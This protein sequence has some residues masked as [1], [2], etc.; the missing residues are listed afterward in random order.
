MGSGTLLKRSIEKYGIDKFKK[1]ILY[2]FK[3]SEEM[4][5]M[6]KE[7]VNEAFVAREDTYN[8]SEGG[9]GSWK[10]LKGKN[11]VQDKNGNFCYVNICD[12]PKKLE[13]G[14]VLVKRVVVKDISGN[15]F[16]VDK[17]DPRYISGELVGHTKGRCPVKD[18]TGNSFMV[19]VNNPRYLSGELVG[20]HTGKVNVVDKEENMLQVSIYDSR[21]LS[22]EL[23]CAVIVKDNNGK[24]FRI[25]PNNIK[26]LSGELKG[27]WS[28]KKHK[29]ETKNKIKNTMLQHKHQQG[30]KNS[31][32]G[33]CWIHNI[34]LKK[35]IVIKKEE[36][37]KYL[38]QNWIKGRKLIF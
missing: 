4:F 33:K 14:F 6:E 9:Y 25:S 37:E 12:I 5:K 31:Q 35:S 3:T 23:L 15:I 38:S 24:K 30:E 13:E 34:E 10:H 26:Y 2:D 29:E 17:N 28:G 8:I 16:Q 32:F 22:G 19:D 36:L 11:L 7:I 27:I 1:E 21:Y 20:I 18:I